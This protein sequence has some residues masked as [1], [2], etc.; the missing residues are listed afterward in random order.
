MKLTDTDDRPLV[1]D[2]TVDGLL[3]V[4]SRKVQPGAFWAVQK[5]GMRYQCTCPAG[6]NN[7]PNCAHVQA[8]WAHKPLLAPVDE[9]DV[10]KTDVF[11][12]G[13]RS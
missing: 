7:R 9:G 5:I 10:F 13:A 6:R 3:F 1:V 12:T 8:A 4:Q 11:Y 2:S